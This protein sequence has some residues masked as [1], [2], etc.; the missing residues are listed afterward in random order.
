MAEVLIIYASDHGGTKRMAEAILKGVQSVDQA[1]GRLLNVE[2]VK[3]EDMQKADAIVLGT[4]VHMGSMDWRIKKFIDQICAGLWMS[5]SLIGKL[6]AVFACGSGFGGAGGG[7]ELTMLAM[8]NNLVELG[9]IIIPLPKNSVGYPKG[10]LQWGPYGRAHNE[11]LSPIEGGLPQEK[12]LAA[13]SHGANIARAA[14]ALS[15]QEI[16]K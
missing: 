8:L 6:G 11:D 14:L 4:P 2:Q 15:G 1:T 16:F 9:L 12:T 13:E 5:D 3:K 10:G 7:V